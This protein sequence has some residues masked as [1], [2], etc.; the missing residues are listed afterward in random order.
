MTLHFVY[1]DDEPQLHGLTE[2]ILGMALRNIK[3]ISVKHIYDGQQ[4]VDYVSTNH[5]DGIITDVDMPKK[6]GLEAIRELR[7]ASKN[8]R[9]LVVTGNPT[10]ERTAEI[11]A[12]GV[13]Y[14]FKPYSRIELIA[15]IRS[16]W[17]EY[18]LPQPSRL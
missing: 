14:I 9:T 6:S 17:P 11:T 18:A 2:S 16:V 12:T 7:A 4:L 13:D 15:K 3:P 8:I 1:A 10:A 5:V